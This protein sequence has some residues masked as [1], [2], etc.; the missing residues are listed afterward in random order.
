MGSAA[1]GAKGKWFR[2]RSMPWQAIAA[3]SSW[4]AAPVNTR[5]RNAS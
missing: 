5:E 3:S 1:S 2:L 4:W